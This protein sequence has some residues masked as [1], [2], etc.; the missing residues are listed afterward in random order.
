MEFH[1]RLKLRMKAVRIS[2]AKIAE[3]TGIKA[4]SVSL[5]VTGKTTPYGSR[6][7]ILCK[8]LECTS[9]WLLFGHGK[10]STGDKPIHLVYMME[11]K[12]LEFRLSIIESATRI[13]TSEATYKQWVKDR[14][15]PDEY[16]QAVEAF[17]ETHL[18]QSIEVTEREKSL[19]DMFRKMDSSAQDLLLKVSSEQ[20]K[21]TH[22]NGYYP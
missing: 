9:D 1:D 17:V 10:P 16:T 14:C 19:I 8:T 3:L 21:I 4:A 5:W 13:G 20:K 18:T 22:S 6:L 15:I 7:Q 2:G 12:R 11:Q